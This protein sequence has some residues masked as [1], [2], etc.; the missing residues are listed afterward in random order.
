MSARRSSPGASS[1]ASP[2]ATSRS[3]CC[4]ASTSRSRRARSSRC[5]ARRARAS[6][7]LL[8]A[9]G[10]LEGGFEGSIR[11]HG[12]EA[13]ELDDDGR[14]RLR[15][16]LLG[17]VY[18]FHHLL[19]EFTAR[20]ECGPSPV[21]ARRRAAVRRASAPSNCSARSASPSGS[22]IA[23]PSFR[24]ASSSASPSPARSPTGRRWCWPTSRPATSTSIPP[25]S[26]SPNS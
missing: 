25:T 6:R 15:R 3:R 2:R 24:A 5:S 13:A 17:F 8:Q 19:P 7:P 12:E 11:L 14:T 4:A 10:L 23:R 22:T 16:E 1:A 26:S 21:G 9:V 18:Q 20:R